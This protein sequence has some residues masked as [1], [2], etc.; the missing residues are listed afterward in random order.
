MDQ[1]H[2]RR[3]PNTMGDIGLRVTGLRWHGPISV[4]G[5]PFHGYGHAC[6]V[7]PRIW[8]RGIR[9]GTHPLSSTGF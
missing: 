1:P 7:P 6:V 8:G 3:V 9:N 4:V 5:T 2:S